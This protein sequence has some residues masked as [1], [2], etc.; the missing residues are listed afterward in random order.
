MSQKT[1]NI[2]LEKLRYGTLT[3][4]E[5]REAPSN[6]IEALTRYTD[7][8]YQTKLAEVSLREIAGSISLE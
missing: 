8:Q 1:L 3:P 4:L 5:F 7:A 6:Y 2:T